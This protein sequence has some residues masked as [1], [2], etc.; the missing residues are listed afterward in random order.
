MNLVRVLKIVADYNAHNKIIIPMYRK[1]G[2]YKKSIPLDKYG[3]ILQWI[4]HQGIS[5]RRAL[6]QCQPTDDQKMVN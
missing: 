5:T 2:G 3:A 6:C 4:D 1:P